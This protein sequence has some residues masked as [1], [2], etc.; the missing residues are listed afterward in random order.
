MTQEE[1]DA[2]DAFTE[3]IYEC[4][5]GTWKAV[6]RKNGNTEE[7]WV[8]LPKADRDRMQE[9]PSGIVKILYELRTNGKKLPD[10]TDILNK[11]LAK[12][13]DPDAFIARLEAM[14]AAE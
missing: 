3:P 14:L 7:L 6:V 5:N 2:Y 4:R 13:T 8:V 1:I 11:M 9:L 10:A 12:A